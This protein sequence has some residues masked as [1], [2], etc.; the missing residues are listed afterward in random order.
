MYK[1]LIGAQLDEKSEME[2]DDA[3]FG[4]VISSW[5]VSMSQLPLRSI[6]LVKNK[7]YDFNLNELKIVEIFSE[8][9]V[10]T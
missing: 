3:T 7:T 5:N 1:F 9:P 6:M 2:P 10:Q 4:F 8:K